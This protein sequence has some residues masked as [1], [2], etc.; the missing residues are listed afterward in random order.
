MSELGQHPRQPFNREP[1]EL[2]LTCSGEIGRGKAR[3]LVCAANA[4]LPVV[5]YFDD[6]A[7]EDRFALQDFGI[8]V[9]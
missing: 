1:A 9:A 5:E 3:K 6:L 4:D 2:G 7:G 8:R